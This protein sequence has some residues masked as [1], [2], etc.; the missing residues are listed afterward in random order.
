L[1]PA[2]P[3]GAASR[4]ETPE[5]QIEGKRRKVGFLNPEA[6]LI[7]IKDPV[8]DGSWRK[9]RHGVDLG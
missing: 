3:T 5:I 8:P 7:N 6:G 2:T 4:G 9:A 1:E